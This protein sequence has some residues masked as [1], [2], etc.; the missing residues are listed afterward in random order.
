MSFFSLHSKISFSLLIAACCASSLGAWTIRVL[1]LEATNKESNHYKQFDIIGG[2]KMGQFKAYLE[3]T[4]STLEGGSLVDYQIYR[5]AGTADAVIVNL[6]MGLS[7]GTGYSDAEVQVLQE[8]MQSDVRVFLIG[9]N[10]SWDATNQQIAEEIWGLDSYVT[11]NEKTRGSAGFL[12]AESVS[13]LMS[14]ISKPIY[15]YEPGFVDFAGG[16]GQ[17]EVLI[18]V[19]TAKD[20]VVLGG[21]ND[22]FLWTLDMNIVEG[23]VDG[24]PNYHNYVFGQNL[25]KWLGTPIP[26]PSTYALGAG[27]L[28]LGCALLHRRRMRQ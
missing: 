17:G 27:A 25:A 22:N 8:L 21:K 9:E 23:L 11:G 4:G 12:A 1:D 13:E 18:G 19:D 24:N 2:S 14:G 26:E 28:A 10:A 16:G 7:A 15:L 20:V 5:D 6:P 3:A